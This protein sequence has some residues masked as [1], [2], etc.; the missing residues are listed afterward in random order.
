MA[1]LEY[2]FRPSKQ[3]KFSSGDYFDIIHFYSSE[4]EISISLERVYEQI[5]REKFFVLKS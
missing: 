2:A 1:K 3:K 5:S 4:F